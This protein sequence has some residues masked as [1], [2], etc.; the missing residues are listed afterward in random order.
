MNRPG[1]PWARCL[2]AILSPRKTR[3]PTFSDSLMLT[4]PQLLESTTMDAPT[5]RRQAPPTP[6]RV[7]G[8]SSRANRSRIAVARSFAR[9][10][11]DSQGWS[12]R[13]FLPR[14]MRLL[15]SDQIFKLRRHRYF[16]ANDF[17]CIRHV[18]L[19]F[20]KQLASLMK[21]QSRRRID[22]QFVASR[23]R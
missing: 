10:E 9:A 22:T 12:P 6:S 21:P 19:R 7:H 8:G 1:S 4:A 16:S 2:R 13:P 11:K 23:P 14:K 5:E 20:E 15:K 3:Y 18:E 17:D